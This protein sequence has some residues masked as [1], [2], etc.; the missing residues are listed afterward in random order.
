MAFLSD[1]LLLWISL[2]GLVYIFNENPRS[3]LNLDSQMSLHIPVT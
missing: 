1:R 3:A 2:G